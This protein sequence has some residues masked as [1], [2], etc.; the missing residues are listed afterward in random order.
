[1]NKI[2]TQHFWI[3]KANWLQ[4][5]LVIFSK[6]TTRLTAIFQYNQLMV[7]RTS[8]FW[9]LLG[10]K[11]DGGSGDNCSCKPCKAPVKSSPLTNQ[12]PDA[13]LS[14]KQQCQ[15]TE[16]KSFSAT[17]VPKSLPPCHWNLSTTSEFICSHTNKPIYSH[18]W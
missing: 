11:N 15:S 7:S 2:T 9:I 18:H 16:S 14:P 8:A 12:H 13:F 6:T 4:Y 1:M 10:G 17:V 3:L 5:A